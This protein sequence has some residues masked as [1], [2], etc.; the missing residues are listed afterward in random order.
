MMKWITDAFSI[1]L[2]NIFH[3]YPTHTPQRK[4]RP[5]KLNILYIF[6]VFSIFNCLIFVPAA[7]LSLCAVS[8]SPFLCCTWVDAV[9][10]RFNASSTWTDSKLPCLVPLADGNLITTKTVHLFQLLPER[11][12]NTFFIALGHSEIVFLK[13]NDNWY[14]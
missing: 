12:Y 4:Y 10:F 14:F 8:S 6:K 11:S 3:Y 7:T 2:N 13:K 9:C 5:C 1:E